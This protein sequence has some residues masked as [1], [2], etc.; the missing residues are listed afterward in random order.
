MNRIVKI[1]GHEYVNPPTL[2]W[3]LAVFVALVLFFVLPMAMYFGMWAL[4]SWLLP[5]SDGWA[6]VIT[7]IIFVA[8]FVRVRVHR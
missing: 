8:L 2:I 3:C 6:V 7:G 1:G 4:I 5:V